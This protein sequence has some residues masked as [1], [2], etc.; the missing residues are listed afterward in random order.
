VEIGNPFYPIMN[1]LF[2][3]PAAEPIE[4]AAGVI[5][6]FKTP[7]DMATGFIANRYGNPV[8]PLVLGILPGLVLVRKANPNVKK[9]A[10]LA[11]ALYFLWYLGVQRPRNLLSAIGLAALVSAY[12]AVELGRRN[13][14]LRNT[15]LALVSLFLA[16]N[17]AS[18]ARTYLY[19]LRYCRY[20]VGIESR[21]DFLHRT[22]T[23]DSPW[24]SAAL[25]DFINDRLPAD[26]VVVA[27][28]LGNGY[29]IS[30]PF[31]DSRMIDGDFMNDTCK[32]EPALLQAWKGARATHVFWNENYIRRVTQSEPE[33]WT[34]YKIVQDPE[35]KRQ[36]L[37]LVIE[38]STQSLYQI[39]Y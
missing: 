36:H 19:N 20:V 31:L 37:R 32:D 28:Y 15:I 8:G 2:G 27:L 12:I 23:S 1:K 9:A 39:V 10:L 13:P 30:K 38:D 22:L 21:R 4:H 34:D 7:W 16:L 11:L 24:P 33:R 5:G 26:A 14:F 18:Y 6:F 35:F 29:Y 17:L 25:T 3:L